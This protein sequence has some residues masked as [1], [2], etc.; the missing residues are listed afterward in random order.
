MSSAWSAG[1]VGEIPQ[2]NLDSEVLLKSN[3]EVPEAR[4]AARRQLDHGDLEEGF[5]GLGGAHDVSGEAAVGAGPGEG[6]GGRDLYA[7]EDGLPGVPGRAAAITGQ[8][9]R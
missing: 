5:D 2:S 4:D 9:R 6:A 3:S 7:R 1:H 8:E